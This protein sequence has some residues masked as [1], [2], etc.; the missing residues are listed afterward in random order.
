[1][2]PRI[3]L[4]NVLLF[5]GAIAAGL[6]AAALVSRPVEARSAADAAPLAGV[7]IVRLADGRMAVKDARGSPVPVAPYQRIV[8]LDLMSSELMPEL[9]EPG[10]VIAVSQWTQGPRAWKQAGVPKLSGLDDLERILTA[11]PDLVLTATF[12]GELDRIERLR[13]AG[14]AVYD[15]G[16]AGGLDALTTSIR[17]I[18]TVIGEPAH[19]EAL[20][21]GFRRRLAAV[22]AHLPA[23][24]PRRKALVLTPVVN[25]VY[26]GT[27]GSSFHDLLT[28]AGLV[29]L[30]AGKYTEGWPK[31]GAEEVLGLDPELVVTRAGGAAELR[32]IPGFDRLPAL[33]EPGRVIE[34]DGALYDGPGLTLL[35]AAEVLCDLAY[36]DQQRQGGR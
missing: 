2:I 18:A 34:L 29:D 3:T 15:L 26:G 7:E 24:L 16:A 1:M 36:P 32:R 5:A 27:V 19:G 11:K 8:C 20:A 12:G 21:S 31:L 28:A 10:R 23:D 4:V 25:T 13:G 33:V 30:A 6:T 22:A 17:R 14:V 35:D 9:V